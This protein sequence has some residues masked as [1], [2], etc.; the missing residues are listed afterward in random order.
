LGIEKEQDDPILRKAF[1][2][3][4]IMPAEDAFKNTLRGRVLAEARRVDA[5]GRG[6]LGSPRRWV[7]MAACAAGALIAA[8]VVWHFTASVP[9]AA[10]PLN[11]VFRRLG[12][13]RSVTYRITWYADGQ[14]MNGVTHYMQRPHLLRSESVGGDVYVHN[15]L[16]GVMVSWSTKTH[17]TSVSK[18]AHVDNVDVMTGLK[19]IFGPSGQLVRQERLGGEDCLVYRVDGKDQ[20]TVVWV[21]AHTL[22]PTRI[23]QSMPDPAHKDVAVFDQFRWDKPLDP[24]MFSQS[25]PK[26]YTLLGET[27]PTELRLAARPNGGL[28]AGM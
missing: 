14:A 19:S 10:P 20:L 21:D 22:L 17:H 26:G 23:E 9:K 1:V 2:G 11:E 13:V 6:R 16:A 4:K 7:A 28:L 27:M 12:G 8:A 15:Y 25:P 18:L 3:M 24:S 5:S